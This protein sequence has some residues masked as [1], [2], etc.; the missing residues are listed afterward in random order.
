MKAASDQFSQGREAALSGDF[1]CAHDRF[2]RALEAMRP[3]GA[4]ASPTAERLAFELDL[5]E[6][7]LR[8]EALSAPPEETAAGE[9]TL[10]P[11]LAPL[12]AP[13]ASDAEISQLIARVWSARADRYSEIRT[14]ETARMRK[15]EMSYIGG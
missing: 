2:E 8:Y 11:E 1:A 10:A 14:A 5:Y 15:V 7:I 9:G 13:S 3:A 6:G 12:E 4:A